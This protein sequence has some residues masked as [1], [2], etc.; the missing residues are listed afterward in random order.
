MRKILTLL[1]L[2][3]FFAQS[4]TGTF[5]FTLGNAARTSAGVFKKDSTLVRTLWADRTYS[6]GTYT[7]YWDG[8]DDYGVKLALPDAAYDIRVLSN[9]VK[10]TWEGVAGNTSTY[11]TG[12]GI[13]RGFY[14]SIT[15]M[16]ITGTTAYYCQ[17][18]SEGHSSEIKFSTLNPQVKLEIYQGKFSTMN[19]DYVATDGINVYWAGYDAYVPANSFVHVTKV[20]DDSE[21]N[22]GINGA[23]YTMVHLGFAKTYNSTIDMLATGTTKP[24]GLAVQK[25]GN[26]LF[27]S[28]N[29]LN[30]VHVLNKTTGALIQNYTITTPG[31]VAVDGAYVWIVSGTNTVAKYNINSDGT[32]GSRILTLSG[33]TVPGAI[34]VSGS[35]IAVIDGGTSQVV[36]FFNTSTGVQGTQLGVSGGY[37]SSPTVT[38]TKF[39]FNDFRGNTNSFIAY[40]PDGSFWVGDPGNY[41]ELHFSSVNTHI[42]TIMSLGASYSICV[43]PNNI[44]RLFY[45][46]LEFAIDYTKPLTGNTGW[47]LVRNWG[48]PAV[49][50]A[51]VYLRKLLNVVTL[52]NGRTYGTSN[53][54]LDFVELTASGMRS[55]GIKLGNAV[56]NTDGSLTRFGGSYNVG[57]SV[58]LTRF[59]LT[60]FDA[61]GNPI[62]SATGTLI[63][64]TPTN[65]LKHPNNYPGNVSPTSYNFITTSNKV[66][67][68]NPSKFLGGTTT[69]YDGYHLG[70]IKKGTSKWLWETQRADNINY[71][72]AFPEAD[73]FELGNSVNQYAGSNV[74]VIDN[75]IFTGHHGEF[76][77]N[78][79]TNYYNHYNEDGLAIGQFGTDGWLQRYAVSP[80]GYAGNALSPLAVKDTSGN[81]YLYHGDEAQHAGVHR[82]KITNLNSIQEKFISIPF[83]QSYVGPALNYIDLHAG[84]PWYTTV[85]ATNG[86]TTSGI[87]T[88]I[89][90]SK[91]Y[92]NDNSPDVYSTF[93]QSSG[94]ASVRRDLGTNNVSTS[95]KIS[96]MLSYE[97]SDVSAGSAI[98]AYT[99]VLDAAGK[100]I[101]RFYYT[102]A[103]STKV[104]TVYGN[105]AIIVSAAG[106]DSVLQKHQPWE[107]SVVNGVV[108]FNYAGFAPAVTTIFDPSANWQQP[109]TLRQYFIGASPTYKKTMGFMD[110][111][112]YKD[113]SANLGAPLYAKNIENHNLI[114]AER[115]EAKMEAYE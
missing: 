111:R 92:V 23:K 114:A 41:R 5:T 49:A 89:T 6:A 106:I 24:S 34:N 4:Q 50:Q 87:I 102:L 37:A 112:F 74:N 15:G 84:L 79:Q 47:K 27:V 19:A 82:W 107:V 115:I 56:V 14:V 31:G 2:I 45:N 43:D 21:V 32:I 66:I 71:R 105:S 35:T 54:A 69:V 39:L 36:R 93:S 110:M 95:W 72:G 11:N 97:F 61:A 13:H 30:E 57:S 55:T 58:T 99:D 18:Y 20:S 75:N 48:Y 80:A 63:A 26:D 38:N 44:K 29:G 103:H 100:V 9:N 81:I 22:F 64:S 91:K 76:W 90:G 25:N 59:P 10:Y 73:Y 68:Y 42:E 16:A 94:T 96:G 104:L 46:F 53:T 86:W 67:F 65:S 85:P 8:K 51:N 101:T 40:A 108:T 1:L 62:W 7:E 98:N 52:S 3:P 28:H 12:S 77:K 113:Y 70:A 109:K 33:I 17:G 78:F 88:T 83:P 60:G